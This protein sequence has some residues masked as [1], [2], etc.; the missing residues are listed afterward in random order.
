MRCLNRN[1][2]VVLFFVLNVIASQVVGQNQNE[3]DSIPELIPPFENVFQ[4]SASAVTQIL[5]P[6]YVYTIFEPAEPGDYT[7]VSVSP[8]ILKLRLDSLVN[9]P[10]SKTDS[11]LY[12]SNPLVLPLVYVGKDI[13]QIWSGEA[14]IR[15]WLYPEKKSLM[16]VDTNKKNSTEKMVA[17]LRTDAR[18]YI[19]NNSMHLYV[20]TMDRLP[21]LSSFMSRPILGKKLEKLDVYDDKIVLNSTKIEYENVKRR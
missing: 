21:H 3:R 13:N 4:D 11:L 20:T 2:S 18:K 14:R 7:I 12:A 9:L 16:F 15:E 1:I 10:I 6:A 17:D 5:E 19:A 8:E